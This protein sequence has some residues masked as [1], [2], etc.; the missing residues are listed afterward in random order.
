MGRLSRGGAPG[1]AVALVA[2]AALP[3]VS[4][5]QLPSIDLG[6][7]IELLEDEGGRLTAADVAREPHGSRF[8]P[9]ADDPPNLGYSSS[10]FWARISVALPRGAPWLLGPR[11]R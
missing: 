11:D 4:A 5:A 6:P 8:R 1:A 10:V 7:R 3:S 2:I 9:S